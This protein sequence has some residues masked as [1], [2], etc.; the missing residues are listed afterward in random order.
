MQATPRSPEERLSLARARLR[1]LASNPARLEAL[2]RGGPVEV[3]CELAYLVKLVSHL[4][5]EGRGNR[6]VEVRI[7]GHATDAER[8]I[9]A[10]LAASHTP[11]G[12]V[13]DLSTRKVVPGMFDPI[14]TI[15]YEKRRPRRQPRVK[16]TSDA[17]A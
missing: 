1:E 12:E 16:E 13:V 8:R 2:R 7:A 11:D 10:R 9:F 4:A 6:P 5:G 17:R 3:R 15:T 14:P